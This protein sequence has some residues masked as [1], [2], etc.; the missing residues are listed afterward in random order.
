MEMTTFN[1]E[2]Y[3]SRSNCYCEICEMTV[4]SDSYY[5][6]EHRCYECYTDA[7]AWSDFDNDY[8]CD[9]CGAPLCLKLGYH[10]EDH[11]DENND[12]K[13]DICK[14]YVCFMGWGS[15]EFNHIDNNGDNHCD[16]CNEA[17]CAYCHGTCPWDCVNKDDDCYCDICN[18]H[19]MHRDENK[20]G[21]C[22][23][24]E[25]II[26]CELGGPCKGEYL[27]DNCVYC[28]LDPLRNHT[29]CVDAEDDHDHWCD[30]CDSWTQ[31]CIA[32]PGERCSICGEYPCYYALC[33]DMNSDC[34]CD[35]CGYQHEMF[36]VDEDDNLICEKCNMKWCY[37]T[38]HFDENEDGQCDACGGTPECYHCDR[39]NTGY[40]TYCGKWICWL[41]GCKPDANCK[42]EGCG[43]IC[44]SGDDNKD[45]H[46]DNCGSV[47]GC[48][49]GG[50]CKAIIETNCLCVHCGHEAHQDIQTHDLS[51]D[52]CGDYVLSCYDSNNDGKCDIDGRY[53]CSTT[54]CMSNDD[55]CLCDYCGSEGWHWDGK[56]GNG[57]C[58]R[59]GVVYCRQGSCHDNDG[60]GACDW[61]GL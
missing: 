24:C 3:D 19:E 40:C 15:D 14:E 46:C 44:H 31:S 18:L 53:M 39:Y 25:N 37:S 48:Q 1:C 45:S 29:E 41:N 5:N 4:H 35:W 56:D 20:D 32:E 28:G 13:C 57:Y 10:Y 43:T 23:N 17:C 21:C 49:F 33:E 61:C 47:V 54:C 11:I 59:C 55:D 42:C 2:H 34:K 26:G 16:I 50:N 12:N 6:E 8:Y 22:D 51:C 60:N 30:V 58:D 9:Y 27:G 38:Y 52:I 7:P 36:H